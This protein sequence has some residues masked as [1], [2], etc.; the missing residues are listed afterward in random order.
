MPASVTVGFCIALLKPFGPVQAKLPL[1]DPCSWILVVAQVRVPPCA[2]A[3]GT[4]LSIITSVEAVLVQ[5][6]A[7]VTVSS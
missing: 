6:F 7:P 1:P 5:P 4:S 3:E 2:D